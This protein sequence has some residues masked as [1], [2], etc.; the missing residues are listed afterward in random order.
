MAA[1]NN[2]DDPT[3]DFHSD[4]MSRDFK[5]QMKAIGSAVYGYETATEKIVYEVLHYSRAR[6]TLV[7]EGRE[8]TV[9]NLALAIIDGLNADIECRDAV[10]RWLRSGRKTSLKAALRRRLSKH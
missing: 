7:A 8:L 2:P 1:K 10:E 4:E 3:F 9:Q 5:R 6:E